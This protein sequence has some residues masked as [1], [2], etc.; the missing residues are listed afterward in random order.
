VTTLAE[1]VA[2]PEPTTI[3]GVVERLVGVEAALPPGDGVAWFVTLYVA[4]TRDVGAAMIPGSFRDPDFLLRLDLAFAGVFFDALR[5]SLASPPTIPKAWA[6]LFDARATPGIVPI[7]FALAGMNAHINRDLPIAL[8]TT[9]EA[10]GVDLA[11]AAP[12]RAD[13]ERVNGIL[14]ATEARVKQQFATGLVGLADTALGDVDDRIAMWDI[15][16]ARD[17]AWVQAQTLWTL[18]TIPAL[19]R[20]AMDTLDRM[21]GFAGRGLLVPVS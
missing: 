1:V 5:R 9:C 3:D 7:Q 2:A 11:A 4:V 15:G 6:P 8:V 14:A 20:D 18:R 10:A 16:R 13:F 17:A 21:I 12:E 19:Q